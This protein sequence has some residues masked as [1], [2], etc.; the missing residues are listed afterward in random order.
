M[1]VAAALLALMA[2]TAQP[3]EPVP[4]PQEDYSRP[5]PTPSEE[6]L[7]E[8]RRRPGVPQHELPDAVNQVNPGAIRQPPPEAFPTEHIAVPDRW[9]L[10]ET[11]G[12][13]QPRWWDPYNQN[14]LKGDIPICDPAD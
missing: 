6:A 10:A 2:S 8:D 4:E 13:V 7:I 11:L 5:A 12:L 14:L 9:R 3:P 1:T